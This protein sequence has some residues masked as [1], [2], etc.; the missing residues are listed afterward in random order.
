M[1]VNSPNPAEVLGLKRKHFRQTYEVPAET[2][3]PATSTSSSA[4]TSAHF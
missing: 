1:I 4:K 3:D 2:I